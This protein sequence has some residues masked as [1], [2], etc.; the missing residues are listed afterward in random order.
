MPSS[1]GKQIAHKMSATQV[2][3]SGA[4]R[5]SMQRASRDMKRNI[6]A[7]LKKTVPSMRLKNA[8][9]KSTSTGADGVASTSRGGA[10]LSV[11][12]STRESGPIATALVKA[13]GP[14]QLVNNDTKAHKIYRKAARVKGKGSARINQQQKLNEV[15][16][17][18]GAYKGGALKL[19][20]GNYRHV[21]DHPGT[22]GKK[23]WQKGVAK[24]TEDA[25][26]T[27]RKSVSDALIAGMR[28]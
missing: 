10:K 15:F 24:G 2:K 21:V 28:S 3:L 12:Y 17:G 20:D 8:G 4:T 16:G 13:N 11:S 19:P 27:M 23:M 18:K 9:K 6:E 22:K 25:I 5:T 7:E 14:W 26:K 1:V